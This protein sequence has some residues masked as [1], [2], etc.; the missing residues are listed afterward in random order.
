MRGPMVKI[1]QL[2][3]MVP[4]LLPEPYRRALLE[5]CDQVPPMPWGLAKR[6]M[7]E[8]LGPNWERLFDTFDSKA[9]F[10]ASLGQVH[11]AR[12]HSGQ[13]VACKIQYPSVSLSL[14]SDLQSLGWVLRFYDKWSR[15]IRTQNL[16]EELC[17]RLRQ[18]L[19]YSQEARH[20]HHFRSLFQD[21]PFVT[22][23]TVVSHLSTKD[24]LTLSWLEGKTMN[25]AKTQPQE[26]R[27]RIAAQLIHAW[28]R[29]FFQA[30]WMHGDP[31]QGNV[32]WHEQG[33][34]LLDWGCARSFSKTFVRGIIQ[35]Y[36]GTLHNNPAQRH[37]AYAQWG[38]HPLNKAT[39]EGLDLWTGFLMAPFV[40]PRAC[41]LSDVS[42]PTQGK[43]IAQQ[44]H[45][46]FR[47]AGGVTLPADL[48]IFDRVAVVLGS[49]I[50]QLDAKAVW[51]DLW[52]GVQNKK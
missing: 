39:C 20:I 27:N 11:A 28:Y 36:E 10:A 4:E 48:L 34:N 24:V 29:P 23:P 43:A 45:T 17:T 9:R 26:V 46:S 7:A 5:L 19:D 31:H 16:H 38:V 22:L 51:S 49:L 14:E 35:L 50:M 21:H 47:Q 25:Q 2:T 30:G 15:A 13:R 37:D 42:C 40:H 33:I 12:L 8:S 32:T 1:A 18:E 44:A 52:Q 6:C 3:A 41:A